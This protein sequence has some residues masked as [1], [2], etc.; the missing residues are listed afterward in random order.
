MSEDQPHEYSRLG[1]LM[2]KGVSLT[3][4]YG[5]TDQQQKIAADEGLPWP[6][7]RDTN[8]RLSAK[9]AQY[10]DDRPTG[11]TNQLT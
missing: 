8:P 1:S 11:Q 4:L 10:S 3:Y 2:V 6:E 7:A 5:F 9:S